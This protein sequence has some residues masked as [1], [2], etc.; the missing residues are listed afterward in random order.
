MELNKTHV[1]SPEIMLALEDPNNELVVGMSHELVFI[2]ERKLPA[3][4]EIKV[5]AHL[6]IPI[7]GY[8][9][10]QKEFTCTGMMNLDDPLSLD[11]KDSV[12]VIFHGSKS[13][14]RI[15]ISGPVG[16]SVS[17]N[18]PVE[19]IEVFEV[20]LLMRNTVEGTITEINV[21]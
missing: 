3:G 7:E 9:T 8:G 10:F 5:T 4:H 12:S 19:K 21:Q 11:T 14:D 18:T 2:L 20:E 6:L 13:D 17:S 1:I 16:W 15:K